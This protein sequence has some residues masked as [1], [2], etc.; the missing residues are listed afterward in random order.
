MVFYIGD[1]YIVM[2]FLVLLLSL[3]SMQNN[4]N[5]YHVDEVKN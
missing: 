4:L 1:Y 2:E 3:R 5:K